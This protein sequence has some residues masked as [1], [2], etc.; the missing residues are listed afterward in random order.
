MLAAAV[1]RSE[2]IAAAVLDQ[3]G[4][5]VGAVGGVEVSEGSD[6]VGASSYLEH[7]TVIAQAA[8]DRRTVKVAAAVFD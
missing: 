5:G 7:S 2:E 8:I 3:A 1:S 4:M 6:G